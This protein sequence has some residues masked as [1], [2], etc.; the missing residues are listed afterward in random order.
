MQGL[1]EYLLDLFTFF[2]NAFERQIRAEYDLA[3]NKE[4]NSATVEEEFAI[5]KDRLAKAINTANILSSKRKETVIQANEFHK[6]IDAHINL[7]QE[8]PKSVEGGIQEQCKKIMYIIY[9]D[10]MLNEA[11]TELYKLINAQIGL[12]PKTAEHKSHLSDKKIELMHDMAFIAV[13]DGTFDKIVYETQKRINSLEEMELLIN[14]LKIFYKKEL[15]NRD[16]IGPLKEIKEEYLPLLNAKENFTEE[17]ELLVNEALV[18][19]S[20]VERKLDNI[21]LQRKSALKHN[22]AN[23]VWKNVTDEGRL[24]CSLQQYAALK[25]Y[26]RK[27]ELTG[28]RFN[29]DV[30]FAVAVRER[31]REMMIISQRTSSMFFETDFDLHKKASQMSSVPLYWENEPQFGRKTIYDG[32]ILIDSEAHKEFLANKNNTN[33]ESLLDREANAE[34]LSIY[35]NNQK[36]EDGS[37]ISPEKHEEYLRFK[38][39]QRRQGSYHYVFDW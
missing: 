26:E 33:S 1:S 30:A 28:Q 7:L 35:Y 13:S 38:A 37:L 14:N 12:H 36:N 9:T 25:W 31:A 29:Y 32:N 34:F 5:L 2:K 21:L 3:G 24:L 10:V 39:G 11:G 16:V 6:Y 23:D 20:K 8:L 15:L 4:V 27:E 18:G 22:A 17:D 19:L